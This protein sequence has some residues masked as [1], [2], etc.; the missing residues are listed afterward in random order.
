MHEVQGFF[1]KT[2][3]STDN[4]KIAER[5]KNYWAETVGRWAAHLA[6]LGPDRWRWEL[7]TLG[8]STGRWRGW[9]G[10]WG[11]KAHK[12]IPRGQRRPRALLVL[13]DRKSSKAMA[14][15]WR[16]LMAAPVMVGRRRRGDKGRQRG[17][18]RR[19]RAS[20]SRFWPDRGGGQRP[21]DSGV[22]WEGRGPTGRSERWRG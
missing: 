9:A 2:G 17:G 19:G 11:G 20:G 21:M 10:P 3:N 7:L 1:C 16:G 13:H 22:T 6:G 8:F 18:S 14:R 12:G 5:K 4:V 15:R